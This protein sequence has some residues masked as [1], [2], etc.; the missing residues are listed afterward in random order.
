MPCQRS[1]GTSKKFLFPMDCD[2]HV[3]VVPNDLTWQWPMLGKSVPI[4]IP[5]SAGSNRPYDVV[6]TSIAADPPMFFIDGLLTSKQISEFK[7]Y[8]RNK[9]HPRML[10]NAA[11]GNPHTAWDI[12]NSFQT[13]LR[14]KLRRALRLNAN[15]HFESIQIARYQKGQAYDLHYDRFDWR[16]EY[17][18]NWDPSR[19]GLNRLISVYISLDDVAAE[20]GGHT[21]FPFASKQVW[22]DNENEEL[23]IDFPPSIKNMFANG[24]WHDKMFDR[25][26]GAATRAADAKP[27]R[28]RPKAGRALVV[29]GSSAKT[30]ELYDNSAIHGS[31]PILD[32]S[33]KWM[34]KLYIW[35][36]EPPSTGH[37][38]VGR[39]EKYEVLRNVTSGEN[40]E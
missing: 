39:L 27:L 6:L 8:A 40:T 36:A 19:G 37:R 1:D 4:V 26:Y 33:V 17:Q 35:N 21:I 16:D 7:R 34:L 20:S 31:C 29:Y 18:Q 38:S 3:F 11:D 32:D 28:I 30:G 10:V 13:G 2:L 22:Q 25:C 24:T 15:S 9:N 23:I 14:Q 12:S 5:N